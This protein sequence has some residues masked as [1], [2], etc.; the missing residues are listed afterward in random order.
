[1]SRSR[2]RTLADA[3]ALGLTFPACT[4]AGYFLGRW[5]D[6]VFHTGAVLSYAGGFLG[7]AAAFFNL[8]LIARR[9]DSDDEKPE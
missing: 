5:L 9:A 2:L 3:S 4:L 8:Y 6:S 1:L 7:S